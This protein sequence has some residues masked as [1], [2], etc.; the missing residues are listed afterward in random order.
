MHRN[1]TLSNCIKSDVDTSLPQAITNP[2]LGTGSGP[3]STST[4]EEFSNNADMGSPDGSK[5]GQT[6]SGKKVVRVVRRVVRRLVPAGTEEQNQP[7]VP[8][9]ANSAPAAES[10]QKTST[11]AVE[12]KDDISVGLTNL[13][14]RGR[15]REHRHPIRPQ[16]GKEDAKEKVKQE[17]E[18]EEV[19]EEEGP[20]EKTEETTS[21]PPP[22][23]K[24]KTLSPPAPKPD[25]LAP[26]PGFIPVPKQ[27]LLGPPPGFIPARKS[28]S[29]PRKPN[30]L[31]RPPGFIPVVKTDPLAPPAGFIPKPCPVVIK[32]QEVLSLLLN[33]W[34]AHAVC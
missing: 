23:L 17:E 21:V 19:K 5:E 7:A 8:E 34:V 3:Q 4:P 9:A 18:R 15:T 29:V 14:G 2:E 6:S 28:S 30:P 24:S 32:K 11:P 31:A 12:D 33:L 27:N 25:P 26:P 1:N 16:D 13:M 22:S 20:A 10:V